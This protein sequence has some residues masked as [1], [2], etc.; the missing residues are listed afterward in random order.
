[1][2]TGLVPKEALQQLY[3]LSTIL[4]FRYHLASAAGLEFS[5]EIIM[6]TLFLCSGNK[7][8]F[9]FHY[10]KKPHKKQLGKCEIITAIVWDIKCLR[11]EGIPL[12]YT[13]F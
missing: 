4:M 7:K 9:C 10:L 11:L 1:M 12:F 2:I 8:L 5:K 13:V 6:T 3:A